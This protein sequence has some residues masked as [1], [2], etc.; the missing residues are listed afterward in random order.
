MVDLLTNILVVSYIG[1]VRV[2][3]HVLKC[4]YIYIYYFDSPE[5]V[6]VFSPS[7]FCQFELALTSIYCW[8]AIAK[9]I[10][11]LL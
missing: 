1:N 8:V 9:A 6:N 7:R 5:L 11:T 4:C 10:F 2:W 3:L